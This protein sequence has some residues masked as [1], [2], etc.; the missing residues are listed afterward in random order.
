MT[1]NAETNRLT[2]SPRRGG[3]PQASEPIRGKDFQNGQE[4]QY[5]CRQLSAV[6]ASVQSGVGTTSSGKMKTWR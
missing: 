3:Q 6:E 4:E 1:Q 2:I 5:W